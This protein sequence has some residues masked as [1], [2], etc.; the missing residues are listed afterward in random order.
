MQHYPKT[1]SQPVRNQEYQYGMERNRFW[2]TRVRLDRFCQRE[3]YLRESGSRIRKR[4]LY[5]KCQCQHNSSH[6]PNKK[7]ISSNSGLLKNF[8][9]SLT[10]KDIFHVNPR[11]HRHKYQHLSYILQHFIPR[12]CTLQIRNTYIFMRNKLILSK[13]NY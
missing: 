6:H 5:M 7:S 13:F 3:Q 8:Q 9:G 2:Y 10:F 12:H 4:L 11:V 1:Q